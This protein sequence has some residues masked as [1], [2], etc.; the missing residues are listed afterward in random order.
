MTRK[1]SQHG[2]GHL[3][4]PPETGPAGM[5]V[6]ATV[7]ARRRR[8]WPNAD[9]R[10]CL[11]IAWIR[12]RT[13]SGTPQPP[14]DGAWIQE[15]PT[16]TDASPRPECTGRPTGPPARSG[17]SS[18][19][20]TQPSCPAGPNPGT[21]G[22][23]SGRRPVREIAPSHVP[24]CRLSGLWQPA[25]AS[26]AQGSRSS[27][28]EPERRIRVGDQGHCVADDAVVP[29]GHPSTKPNTPRG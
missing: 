2:D 20:S 1:F 24:G 7:M 18:Y 16:A 29:A 22:L 27:G 13:C 8:G 14:P 5:P 17:R 25:R 4:V 21:R 10:P 3:L 11:P 6:L 15:Q 26:A 12:T 23:H 19:P 28:R 9:A